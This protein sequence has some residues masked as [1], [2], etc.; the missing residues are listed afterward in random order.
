MPGLPAAF[1]MDTP[2]EV[3]PATAASDPQQ[4]GFSVLRQKLNFDID[5]SRQHVRGQTELTLAPTTNALRHI[6]LRCRQCEILSV[7]VEDK[8]ASL[9]YID[10]YRALTPHAGWGIRQ[11]HLYKERLETLVGENALEE[12]TIEVPKK[13]IVRETV[14]TTDGGGPSRP[15]QTVPMTPAGAPD[16]PVAGAAELQTDYQ[17][18]SLKI[19]FA[20]KDVRDGIQFVGFGQGDGRYPC[21]YTRNSPF[22]GTACSLFPCLDDPTERLE[23]EIS[24]KCAKTLGSAL[25]LRHADGA[26][27][28]QDFDEQESDLGDD[29]GLDEQERVMDLAVICSGQFED[30]SDDPSDPTR[31]IVT[32]STREIYCSA[33]QI[34]F[35]VGPFEQVDISDLREV[36]EDD[37]LAEDAVQV[38]AHCM[39]GRAAEVRNTVLPMAKAIDFFTERYTKYF[40]PSYHM[41]F[42][43]DLAPDSVTTAG[44]SFLSTRLLFPQDIIDPIYETTHKIVHALAAQYAGIGVTAREAVDTWCIIGMSHFMADSFMRSL[45]GNNEYR[46]R[47]KLAVDRIVEVDRNRPSLHTLGPILQ[48]D[49]SEL[50]FM[51]MKSAAV[52][53]ILDR[54][55]TKSSTSSGISRIINRIMTNTKGGDAEATMLTTAQFQKMCERTGHTKLETFF[56]QW[57][58]GAGCPSFRVIQRFNKKKLVVEMTIEQVQVPP[59]TESQPQSSQEL[60]PDLFLRDVNEE[61]NEV[62]AGTMTKFVGPMTIRIHEA[63][64]TPYEHIIDINGSSPQKLEIPYNTKY[65]RLKRNRRGQKDQAKAAGSAAQEAVADTADEPL[66]YCLGDV[67]QSEQDVKDWQLSEWGEKEEKEMSEDSYEWIRMDADFEWICKMQINLQAWMFVSQ[68]QQDRD[69]VAQYESLKYMATAATHAPHPLISTFLTRTVMDSRYFHGIR[70]Y[71]IAQMPKN[72]NDQLGWI[73]LNHLRKVFAEFFYTPGTTHV[74]PNDFSDRAQ[75]LVQCALPQA[76]AQISDNVGQVPRTVKRLFVDILKFNDN[77]QNEF[78]DCYWVSTLMSCLTDVLVKSS[79]ASVSFDEQEEED[80]FRKDAISEIERYRRIDEWI[81][82]FQNI[83]SRTALDCLLRLQPKIADFLQ[84]SKPGNADQIR[85]SGFRCLV[86]FGKLKHEQIVRYILR[87]LANDQSPYM[88]QQILTI[89]GRGLGLVA[90][91]EDEPVKPTQKP[92]DG[93][94]IEEGTTDERAQDKARRTTI[95]GATKA[96]K[97]ELSENEALAEGLWEAITSSTLTLHEIWQLLS[98]PEILYDTKDTLLVKLKYPRYWRVRYDGEGRCTFIQTRVRTTPTKPFVPPS[99]ATRPQQE[100]KPSMKLTLGPRN[101]SSATESGILS[102]GAPTISRTPTLQLNMPP[103]AQRPTPAS[104]RAPVKV[105]T[106]PIAERRPSLPGGRPSKIVRLRVPRLKDPTYQAILARISPKTPTLTESGPKRI[107]LS[108]GSSIKNEPNSPKLFAPVGSPPPPLQASMNGTPHEQRRPST[109]SSS[110]SK[111]G[112]KRK[113]SERETPS[114]SG[115]QDDYFTDVNG[116]LAGE[117]RTKKSRKSTSRKNSQTLNATAVPSY[118]PVST[119][120]SQQFGAWDAANDDSGMQFGAWDSGEKPAAP[121]LGTNG[122]VERAETSPSPARRP[123]KIIKLK[124]PGSRLTELGSASGNARESQPHLVRIEPASAPFNAATASQ[125]HSGPVENK[126]EASQATFSGGSA[127]DTKPVGAAVLDIEHTIDSPLSAAPTLP[128]S[129]TPNDADEDDSDDDVPMSQRWRIN[130]HVEVIS[131]VPGP[132]A[133]VEREVQPIPDPSNHEQSHNDFHGNE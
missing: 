100:R 37:K 84:Y 76:L 124:L 108:I 94:I 89:F 66:L 32:Y 102:G 83:Y 56:N 106:S 39:P 127:A 1:A 24:I 77:S 87:S 109:A 91:G 2:T 69:V 35:A 41:C 15:R 79:E 73:G 126:G 119:P 10:P 133:T 118:A 103:P 55:L 45:S 4:R 60:S 13:V 58:H 6:R 17:T 48:L 5:F 51:A 112:Q 110:S 44:L 120:A 95:E 33:N 25:G 42:V 26:A 75:Y 18:L 125:S 36:D 12:M 61:I 111:R 20:L 98:I 71:A 3:G 59:P 46:L 122:H 96:L 130:G 54:R 123:S 19:D 74:R 64:G 114:F 50:E 88:R 107:K 53:Y 31:K 113:S 63:D 131:G 57:V 70:T 78:S 16:T 21:V 72:A 85:L 43:D 14:L 62:Y 11:H 86:D 117:P 65:K 29:F 116:D 132:L 30:E 67:L 129:A 101:P 115:A 38:I 99:K 82:S 93:L 128:P 104:E 34:G 68:L 40:Y 9:Q 8:P 92:S 121:N 28:S 49:P 23:W 90:L 105:E 22:P 80:A 81:P 7:T 27:D 52:L 97:T 47:Q